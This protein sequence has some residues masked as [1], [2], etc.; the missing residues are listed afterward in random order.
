MP[1]R[2]RKKEKQEVMILI[3][4]KS[5]RMSYPK[6][7][8]PELLDKIWKILEKPSLYIQAQLK[9]ESKRK[10]SANS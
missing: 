1:S 3:K 7:I 5:M 6:N 10:K 2:K 8:D 9:D 4:K